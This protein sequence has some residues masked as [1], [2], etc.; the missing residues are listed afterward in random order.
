ME[1][2]AKAGLSMLTLWLE[3]LTLLPFWGTSLESSWL[4]QAANTRTAPA[5]NT[6][7]AVII[8]PAPEE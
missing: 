3:R 2:A 7:K 1:H 8:S 6:R 5:N 4:L